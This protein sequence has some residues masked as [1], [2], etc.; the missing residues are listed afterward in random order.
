[1]NF[2]NLNSFTKKK[3][4]GFYYWNKWLEDM[5]D[6]KYMEYLEESLKHRYTL[7]FFKERDMEHSFEGYV[8]H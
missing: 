2:T 5:T 8:K 4:E 1:M 7:E 3:K 6:E